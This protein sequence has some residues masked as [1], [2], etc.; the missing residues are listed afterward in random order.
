MGDNLCAVS[1]EAQQRSLTWQQWISGKAGSGKSTLMKYAWNSKEL[2]KELEQGWARDGELVVIR[3]YFF[4]SGRSIQKSMEGFL[5]S[6][7]FQILSERRDLIRVAFPSSFDG[8]WPPTTLFTSITN[9]QQGWWTLFSHMARTMRLFILIDGIEEYRIVDRKDH[10]DPKDR[11]LTYNVDAGDE[12]W[13]SNKWIA[14]SNAEIANLFLTMTSKD[15]VKYVF[16]GRELPVFEQAFAGLPRIRMQ[17][18]TEEAVANY[19][20]GRLQVEAPGL[21]QMQSL[22]QHLSQKSNGDV[23]WAKIAID[24]LVESPLRTLGAAIDALPQRLGGTDGLYMYMLKRLSA[25]ERKA[26]HHIFWLALRV[27]QA[28]TI[29]TLALAHEGYLDST[30]HELRVRGDDVTPHTAESIQKLTEDMTHRLYSTCARLLEAEAPSNSNWSEAGQRVVF[31][32]LSAKEWVAR[33]DIWERL[34]VPIVSEVHMDFCLLSGLV[35]HIKTFGGAQKPMVLAWPVPR[36]RPDA[37]FLIAKALRVAERLDGSVSDEE[38]S[39]YFALLDELDAIGQQAWIS[40]LDKHKPLYEDPEWYTKRLPALQ[41]KHWSSCEPMEVGKPPKRKDFLALAVQANLVRYVGEKL[42]RLGADER[43]SRA[44]GLLGCV[45]SPQPEGRSACVALSGDF[46]AFHHDMPDSRLLDVLFAAGAADPEKIW[47]R[48]LKTGRRFF[49]RS[50]MTMTHL[51]ESG[52][53]QRLML[54]RERWVAAVKALLLRGADPRVEVKI[55]TES[56]AD[57]ASS[58]TTVA[59]A[60]FIRE[61]LEGEP[62]YAV[63]LL[64]LEKLMR[65]R[66]GTHEK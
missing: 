17:E 58:T 23:L 15:M 60:D 46:V 3:A 18:H 13:G 29:I 31:R 36:F 11:D 61:T 9:L 56:T 41:K 43:K 65:T 14:D 6:T 10:Y 19:I 64:E 16:T 35:R 47:L 34:G 30:G 49:Q 27:Q 44:Q 28:A 51:L 54:N 37:W 26:A 53:S 50:H 40:A 24:V 2:R 59:A 55:S 62:E 52:A 38:S 7:M 8:P 39:L 22:C 21:P 48:T 32:H 5:R 66:G 4:E 1:F 63:E 42:Q 20:Q 33:R 57:E 12:S 25:E 45:V